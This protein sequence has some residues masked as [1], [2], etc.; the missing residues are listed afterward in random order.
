M[1]EAA[2]VHSITLHRF[3]SSDDFAVEGYIHDPYHYD[4]LPHSPAAEQAGTNTNDA[5]TIRQT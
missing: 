1:S 5:V 4:V 2:Q 3:G